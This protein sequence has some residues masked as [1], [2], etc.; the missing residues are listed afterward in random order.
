[1]MEGHM[2]ED[3]YLDTEYINT[4]DMSKDLIQSLRDLFKIAIANVISVDGDL[5]ILTSKL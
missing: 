1:M 2:P 4:N 3:L 5:D